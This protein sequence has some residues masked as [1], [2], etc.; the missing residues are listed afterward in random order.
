MPCLLRSLF[1]EQSENQYGTC[2]PQI[3]HEEYTY[4]E[5]YGILKMFH[6]QD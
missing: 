6:R 1:V 4:R 5:T 3:L 2:E